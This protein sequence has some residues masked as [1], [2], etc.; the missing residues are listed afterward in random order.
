MNLKVTYKIKEK[1]DADLDQK[2]VNA[3]KPVGFKMWASGYDLTNGVRDLSFDD[4][5]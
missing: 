2:I 4:G 5:K 1:I 3:L